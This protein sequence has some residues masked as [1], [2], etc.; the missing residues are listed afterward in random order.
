MAFKDK[1][2]T[3]KG[4]LGEFE[5]DKYLL[6]IN[7]IPYKP[8]AEVAHPFDRLCATID[9]K[10]IYIAEC[11]TK[12]SRSYYPDTGI[13][14]RHYDEYVSIRDKY[15]IDLYLFFVDEFRK[16]IYGNLLSTLENRYWVKHSGKLL[17]YPLIQ[18]DK[19]GATIIYFPLVKMQKVC[20]ISAESAKRMV[21]LSKRNYEYPTYMT[22][23]SSGRLTNG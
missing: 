20:D 8:A 19:R 12:A 14:K 17:K 4:D 13:D 3:K 7:I 18:T 22:D 15:G 5:L 11:K 10:S 2:S 23:I 1:P 21:E 6:S 9:K 16:E